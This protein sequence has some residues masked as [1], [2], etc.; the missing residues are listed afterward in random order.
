MNDQ[1]NA[2]NIGAKSLDKEEF[3][4]EPS[5]KDAAISAEKSA[6]SSSSCFLFLCTPCALI[7]RC[8]SS[9]EESSDRQNSEDGMFYCTLCEVEVS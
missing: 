8:S 4:T 2:S 9:N 3:G 5:L 6:S 1:A 7:C